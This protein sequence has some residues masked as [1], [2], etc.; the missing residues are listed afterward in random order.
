MA[1]VL[2]TVCSPPTRAD[3]DAGK[4]AWDTGETGGGVD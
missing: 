2:L 3:Y 1:W 4:R